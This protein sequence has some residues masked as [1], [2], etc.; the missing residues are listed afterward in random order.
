MHRT[1]SWVVFCCSE[2][3]WRRKPQTVP[4]DRQ[5]VRQEGDIWV[6]PSKIGRIWG[7]RRKRKI[8]YA[9]ERYTVLWTC[10]YPCPVV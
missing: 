5:D 1:M 7:A 3:I 2:A 8:F 9:H 4:R 6:W 10:S